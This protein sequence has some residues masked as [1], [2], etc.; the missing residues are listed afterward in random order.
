MNVE[1]MKQVTEL[2]KNISI[3][4]DGKLNSET[5]Q[6]IAS[7]VTPQVLQYLYFL[8]FKSIIV[9]LMW[10]IGVVITGVLVGRRLLKNEE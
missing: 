2:V 6:T 7:E 10:V 5:L 3:G 8:Q 1:A 9:N 4:F